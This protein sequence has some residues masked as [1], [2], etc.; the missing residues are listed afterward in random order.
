M[1]SIEE[2]LAHRPSPKTLRLQPKTTQAT[3][4]N[5]KTSAHLQ[6]TQTLKPVWLMVT[7]S[8]ILRHAYYTVHI[9]PN[10]QY[11][12]TGLQINLSLMS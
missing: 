5:A 8:T 6:N 10:C 7:G 1:R 4:Q 11:Y 2:T 9:P 3:S 12:E